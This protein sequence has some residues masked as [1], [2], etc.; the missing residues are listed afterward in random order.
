MACHD[1][2]MWGM[3]CWNWVACVAN[4]VGRSWSGGLSGAWR[5]AIEWGMKWRDLLTWSDGIG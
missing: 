4:E 1:G 3:Q 2:I 5:G